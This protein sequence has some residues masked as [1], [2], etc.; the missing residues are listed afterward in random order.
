MIDIFL[1]FITCLVLLPVLVFAAQVLFAMK[2]HVHIKQESK[3]ARPSVA[4]LVPAHNEADVIKST[5][6]SLTPQLGENDR[7][8]VVADNCD[9]ETAEIAKI[10]GAEVIERTDSK[11]RGKGY[12]LDFGVRYLKENPPDVLI[13]IDADC[14]VEAGAI[15][16]L[17]MYCIDTARPVQALY[18]M[19]APEQAGLKLR[20]AEFAWRVKNHV[21]P[22]GAK[23]L[24]SPCQ[25][26]GTGMAF[27]WSLTQKMALASSHIVEDMKLGID[28]AIAGSPPVFCPEAIVKSYFPVDSD[29]VTSQRTRWEHG[30]LGIILSEFPR[31]FLLGIFRLNPL[32]VA[33]ALDLIVPPLSLL[34]GLLILVLTVTV[35]TTIFGFSIVPLLLSFS[36]FGLFTISVAVA[37]RKWGKGIVTFQEL[38]SVPLY[39]MGKIPIYLRFFTRRQKEWVKT[40]RK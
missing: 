21:R 22:L 39:I 38:L 17:T 24:G 19:H 9:D 6:A 4:L 35:I 31:L 5:L 16:K 15:E 34:A 1:V 13:I 29:T 40:D 3:N 18:L 14:Q 27:P 12:A 11:N 23:V 33:M 7:L 2:R 8:L 36:A 10:A 25:L 32:L 20:I 37:W 28:L 30:H 26:M